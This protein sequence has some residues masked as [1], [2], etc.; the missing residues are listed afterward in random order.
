MPRASSIIWNSP[1]AT[2]LPARTATAARTVERTLDAAHALMSHGVDRYPG[3]KI[4]DLRAEEKRAGRAS[5]ARGEQSSTICG[6]RCRTSRP[7]PK[8]SAHRRAPPCA[9]RPAAGEHPLF[10][11]EDRAAALRP[12]SAS[13]IRI[14]RHIAQ[15]FYPQGQTKV[16]NEGTATYVHYRIMSRLHQQGR[17]TDGNFLEFLQSHTNVVFQPEFDDRRYLRLQPLRARLCDDAGHRAHREARPRT[18]T[19]EV[20]PRHRRQ[21][22]RR[23]RA[24]RYLEPTTATRASSA[25]SSARR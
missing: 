10:P 5:P 25:S 22:R 12:G 14:V 2:S 13:S 4:L 6:G 11:R 18:R 23:G 15:Y 24:A 7:R 3:K 16:M 8:A 21:G 17:I 1:R 9:A 19:V 20:V